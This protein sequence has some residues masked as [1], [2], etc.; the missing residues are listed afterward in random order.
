VKRAWIGLTVIVCL[1]LAR[2][3][4]A[5][6]ARL[7]D[8]P[9]PAPKPE[10]EPPKPKPDDSTQDP[11]PAGDPSKSKDKPDSPPKPGS[12]PAPPADPEKAKT[13]AE[14]GAAKPVGSSAAPADPSASKSLVAGAKPSGTSASDA[15]AGADRVAPRV[16]SS[17]AGDPAS[18]SKKVDASAAPI[19]E[20]NAVS[21]KALLRFDATRALGADAY[22]ALV[23]RLTQEFPDLLHAQSL[24]KSRSGRDLWLLTLGDARAGDPA[25]KPALCVCSDLAPQRFVATATS[26]PAPSAEHASD[27]SSPATKRASQASAPAATLGAE[28]DVPAGPE[29]ALYLAASLLTD[30]RTRPEIASLLRQATLYLLPELDPDRAFSTLRSAADT[31]R[32]PCCIDRNFPIDWT[33][34]GDAPGSHGPYPLSEPESQS[35]A[36]FFAEHANLSAVL[37]LARNEL[38]PPDARRES[39]DRSDG[40]PAALA[41]LGAPPAPQDDST[42]RSVRAERFGAGVLAGEDRDALACQALCASAARAARSSANQARDAEDMCTTSM[43]APSEIARQSGDLPSFCEQFGGLSVF[44]AAPWN[45]AAIETP[46]GAAPAGFEP[47]KAMVVETLSSLPHLSAE[48]PAVERLRNNLWMI[49]VGVSNAGI[50][51]TLCARECL[52][53]A[54]PSVSLKV[55][56][57]KLVAAGWKRADAASYEALRVQEGS[58]SIGHLEG[59]ESV[60]L[61]LLVEAAEGSSLDLSLESARGGEK[62]LKIALQ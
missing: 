54:A 45:G 22:T 2:G 3:D 9:P 6:A 26:T 18:A 56:G 24:G 61:R 40:S 20:A 21:A 57:A 17:P 39:L 15:V 60:R 16:P 11:K 33:P 32:R 28:S 5:G 14:G 30:S 43:R 35:A 25:R 7:Q 62:L 37:L 53:G 48:K 38:E 27:A 12:D 58:A 4:L 34:W 44:A 50:L 31:P 52:P 19:A 10:S 23:E 46:I 42:A 49:D 47:L 1:A 8:G 59:R 29:A 36:L 13:P 55:G 41:A 51:P